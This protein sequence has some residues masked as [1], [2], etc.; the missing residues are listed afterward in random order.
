MDY[1]I[2]NNVVTREYFNACLALKAYFKVDKCE[3]PEV[4]HRHKA[5]LHNYRIMLDKLN[6]KMPKPIHPYNREDNTTWFYLDCKLSDSKFIKVI[7]ND[8]WKY[9]EA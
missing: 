1:S 3:T 5:A 2:L 6:I 8:N 7:I 9:K 4:S